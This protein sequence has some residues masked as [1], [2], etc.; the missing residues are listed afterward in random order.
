MSIDL[1]TEQSILNDRNSQT[2]GGITIIL[3]PNGERSRIEF[4]AWIGSGPNMC[5]WMGDS[6][7]MIHQ[8]MPIL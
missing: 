2:T 1:G 4:F 5:A 6:L 3:F 8:K 7:Y